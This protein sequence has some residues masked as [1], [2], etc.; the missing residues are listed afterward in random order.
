MPARTRSSPAGVRMLRLVSVLL[1]FTAAVGL[2]LGTAGFSAT[3]ADRG[4]AVNVVEDDE[5]YLGVD[6]EGY[7]HVVADQETTVFE[8]E[9]RFGGDLD[10]IEV[11]LTDGEGDVDHPEEIPVGETEPVIVT[12]TC[13]TGDEI[14]LEFG[15]FAT[16]GGVSVDTTV[17]RT[18]ECVNPDDVKIAFDGSGSGNFEVTGP[19][20]AFPLDL[21]VETTQG[22][23]DVTI[24]ESGANPRIGGEIDGSIERVSIPELGVSES[25]PDPDDSSKSGSSD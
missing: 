10:A 19:D 25:S 2:V 5:A 9:N 14:T 16:D 11:R 12:P 1:V 8:L 18:V 17:E 6:T 22:E 4:V 23:R 24:A 13:G 7:D 3:S 20:A 21:V 15:V